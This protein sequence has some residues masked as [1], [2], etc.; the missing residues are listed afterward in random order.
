M[1]GENFQVVFNPRCL[2]TVIVLS[3]NLES[4]G[5]WASK[6]T[7][8]CKIILIMTYL[9]L[10][11][12]PFLG[13]DSRLSGEVQLNSSNIYGSSVFQSMNT[14]RRQACTHAKFYKADNEIQWILESILINFPW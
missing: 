12:S 14:D 4:T 1:L 10:G 11:V 9:L 6:Q 3:S 2:G 5:S 8:M 7:D 13:W